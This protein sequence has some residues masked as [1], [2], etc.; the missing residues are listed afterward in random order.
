MQ[1][2]CVENTF[3]YR[4]ITFELIANTKWKKVDQI[5]QMLQP[6]VA[7]AVIGTQRIQVGSTKS[8]T[9][10]VRSNET[11][12]AGTILLRSIAY[13]SDREPS[14]SLAFLERPCSLHF[15]NCFEGGGGAYE[16]KV[17]NANNKTLVLDRR[18]FLPLTS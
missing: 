5:L 8:Q 15:K 17:K 3:N 4:L 7:N 16:M 14:L 11:Y 1:Q 9:L 18:V 12:K 2:H 13:A 10:K 6:T